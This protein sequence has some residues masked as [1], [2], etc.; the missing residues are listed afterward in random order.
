M[1]FICKNIIKVT[2]FLVIRV[3]L[4]LPY[5]KPKKLFV[6]LRLLQFKILILISQ[7]KNIVL[8]RYFCHNS[9]CEI[10]SEMFLFGRLYTQQKTICLW[11][12][13]ISMLR[14]SNISF[15]EK[16]PLDM[17]LACNLIFE[18]NATPPPPLC[19]LD[20]KEDSLPS[21]KYLSLQLLLSSHVFRNHDYIKIIFHS[22]NYI[23]HITDFFRIHQRWK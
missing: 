22:L 13:S 4:V 12:V 11:F 16:L 9:I 5:I 8:L 15:T 17:T 20:M 2:L 10:K 18:K 14:Q 19:V 1:S 23:Y 7:T 21:I 6:S 3:G